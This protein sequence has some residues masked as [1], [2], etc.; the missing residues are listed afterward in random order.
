MG[1]ALFRFYE[2][3]NDRLPPDKRKR[4]FDVPLEGKETALEIIKKLGVPLAEVDL[5]L[6][7][8]QSVDLDHRVEDGDRVSVY[9]VFERLNIKGVSRVRENPLRTLRFIVDGE[10]EG[11]ARS[12]AKLGVEVWFRGD[13]NEVQIQD[14]A[15]EEQRILL[16]ERGDFPGLH[17]LERRVLLKPGSVQ[18]QLAQVMEA[19]D[20]TEE[21]LR[22][23]HHER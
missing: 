17:G 7:N 10:L 21:T 13:L 11:L 6:V 20:L 19:L 22:E 3:L 12:L 18:E 5:L 4:D 14:L 8:G 23:R 15:K 1:Q 9:P 2:E 16:T